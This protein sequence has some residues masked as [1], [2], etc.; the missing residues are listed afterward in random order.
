MILA[1]IETS[2]RPGSVAL[3]TGSELLEHAL[4]DARR[5]ASDLLPALES[6]LERAGR[7][8]QELEAVA[9]GI[10]P[11]SFT[12]VRVAVATALGL[13]RSTGA[14]LCAVPSFEA[15]VHEHCAPGATLS[16]ALDARAEAYYLARYAFDGARV[17]PLTPPSVVSA[18]ELLESLATDAGAAIDDGV[19]RLL[20][21]NGLDP[22]R[23]RTDLFASARG[24]AHVGLERLARLGPSA[25]EE[26]EPLYLRPFAVRT[27][28]RG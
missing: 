4:T 6:L 19:A 7:D 12:G 16:I 26:C 5:H 22:E 14:A 10:G 9:F 11:G 27:R 17:Q 13:A 24:I 28:K 25:P 20:R 15:L 2:A 1:S 21:A 8:A 3:W 23:H 18:A